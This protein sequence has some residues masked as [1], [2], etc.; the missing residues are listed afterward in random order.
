MVSGHGRVT[1]PE[2]LHTGADGWTVVRS[3]HHTALL[4]WRPS[5]ERSSAPGAGARAIRGPADF[6]GLA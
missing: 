1:G 4:R 2:T 6:E 3:E 5:V